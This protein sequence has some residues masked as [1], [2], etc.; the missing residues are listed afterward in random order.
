MCVREVPFI[1]IDFQNTFPELAGETGTLTIADINGNIVSTQPL[2]YQPN[3]SVQILYPGTAVNPDGS[4]DDVPGW[5]LTD[6]GFW[7][8]DPSDEF[9]REG[10][11]LTYELNPTAG[12]VLVTYPPESSACAN[13]DGPFPPGT[14]TPPRGPG[15][16]PTR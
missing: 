5:I 8:R 4:V 14:T 11:F 16:P 2:V 7:I 12:P 1:Q 10:L 6:D 3:T 9:L 15:L 13:P